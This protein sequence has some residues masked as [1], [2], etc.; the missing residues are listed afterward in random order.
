MIKQ[1]NMIQKKVFEI[2]KISLVFIIVQ[3]ILLNLVKLYNLNK[4]R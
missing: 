1:Q 2:L 3:N 4:L